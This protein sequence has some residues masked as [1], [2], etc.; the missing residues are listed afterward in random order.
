MLVVDLHGEFYPPHCQAM[1]LG[2]VVEAGVHRA[3]FLVRHEDFTAH[4]PGYALGEDAERHGGILHEGDALGPCAH[5]GRQLL[6]G[7]F[8]DGPI[9]LLMLQRI[10]VECP[11]SLRYP[12]DDRFGRRS[13]GAA[14]EKRYIGFEVKLISADRLPKSVVRCGQ[15]ARQGRTLIGFH[16]GTPLCSWTLRKWSEIILIHTRM[17]EQISGY[18][19]T[20][21]A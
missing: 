5:E 17:L 13:D 14:L 16:A 12:V 9:L 18:C 4:F 7:F 3:V 6:P 2:D 1:A 10:A 21:A 11:H 19:L 8:D 15:R 20:G